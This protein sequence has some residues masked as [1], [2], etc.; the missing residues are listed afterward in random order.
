MAGDESELSD[1][2]A[3]LVGEL[4]GE[5]LGCDGSFD[6]GGIVVK[7]SAGGSVDGSGVGWDWS[8]ASCE[9]Q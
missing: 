2:P 5:V 9:L 8:N 6:T 4:G 7:F 3:E 1:W